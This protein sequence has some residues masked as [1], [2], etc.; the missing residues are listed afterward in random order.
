M[1]MEFDTNYSYI[2]ILLYNMYIYIYIEFGKNRMLKNFVES[3]RKKSNLSHLIIVEFDSYFVLYIMIVFPILTISE[4]LK[5][6]A[7]LVIA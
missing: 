7:Q 1:F 5:F 6:F 3:N 2:Y 4:N